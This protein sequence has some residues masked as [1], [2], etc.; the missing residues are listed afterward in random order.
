MSLGLVVHV[1]ESSSYD[2]EVSSV[3][4]ASGPW[5]LNP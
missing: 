4:T 1:V 5:T 2:A 3:S